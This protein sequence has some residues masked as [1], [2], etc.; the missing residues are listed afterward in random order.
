M[1]ETMRT[2]TNLIGAISEDFENDGI[3][4]EERR[5]P[6]G[7]RQMIRDIAEK[8]RVARQGLPAG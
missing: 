2:M 3:L 4:E 6:Q 8:R 7:Y 5:L 1:N